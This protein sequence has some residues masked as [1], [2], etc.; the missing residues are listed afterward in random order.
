MADVWTDIQAQVEREIEIL[1]DGMNRE[2][3]NAKKD[4]MVKAL[5][6]IETRLERLEEK[7]NEEAADGHH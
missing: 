7:L 4:E 3:E 6:S 1:R 5:R 2:I